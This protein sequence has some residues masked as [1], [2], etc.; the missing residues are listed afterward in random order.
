M[1][2]RPGA[3]K[4]AAG[5]DQKGKAGLAI[6]I[7]GGGRPG[8]DQKAGGP[9]LAEPPEPRPAQQP[10]AQQSAPT[11]PAQPTRPAQSQGDEGTDDLQA[12]ADDFGL[13]HDDVREIAT[14]IV[15]LIVTRLG[16]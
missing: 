16:I 8:P 11:Q 13:S 12:I 4:P 1:P 15:D 3:K 5:E 6:I 14:R 9:P 2:E 7:T 10:P